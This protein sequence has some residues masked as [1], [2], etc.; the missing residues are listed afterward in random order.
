MMKELFL[1]LNINFDFDRDFFEN[2]LFL[3]LRFQLFEELVC[4]LHKHQPPWRLFD[5][6]NNVVE[7]VAKILSE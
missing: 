4:V 1:S 2:I 3:W 5:E 6:R 7:H